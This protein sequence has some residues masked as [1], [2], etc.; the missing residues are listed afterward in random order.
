MIKIN[1]LTLSTD[2]VR[3]GRTAEIQV[4]IENLG[5]DDEDEVYIEILNDQLELEEKIGPFD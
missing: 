4:E 1:D 5:R 2:T 3:A